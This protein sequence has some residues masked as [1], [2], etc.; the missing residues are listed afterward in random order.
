[1]SHVK[2]LNILNDCKE[3]QRMAAKLPDWAITHWGI[4]VADS[5]DTAEY[6]IFKQFVAFVEKEGRVACHSV[7]SVHAV[8]G[9]GSSTDAN[10]IQI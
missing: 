2:D 7:A 3:N 8:K 1:M 10:C 4:I 5:L 9:A 6:P